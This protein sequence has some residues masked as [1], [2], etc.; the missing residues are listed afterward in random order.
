MP[1][2]GIDT[3]LNVLASRVGQ[4]GASALA[5]LYAR[6]IR[7][8]DLDFLFDLYAST[9]AEEMA[10]TGWTPVEQQGFLHQ[11]FQFQHRYYQ[12]HYHDAQFLLLLR[13][14]TPIGRLYWWH[15]ASRATLI[16]ISLMPA[17]RGQGLGSAVLELLTRQVDKQ[18]QPI[19][20]HVEPENPA[21]RLYRRFGFEVVADN[22][23]YLKMERAARALDDRA[24]RPV[25]PTQG[26]DHHECT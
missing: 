12:E 21:H 15:T 13:R 14:G 26:N 3:A 1:L 11:Q 7:D 25:P 4:D 24:N 18:A 9:R 17:V 8:E 19:S 16:D 23:V 20:L 10:A 2:P 5:H 22:R 6:P